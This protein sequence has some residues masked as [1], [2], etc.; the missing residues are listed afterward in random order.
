M[1]LEQ[2]IMGIVA[3]Q[4]RPQASSLTHLWMVSGALLLSVLYLN[5]DHP[6]SISSPA[7]SRHGSA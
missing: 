1:F 2:S 7:L 5:P 6:L 4:R 3:Q